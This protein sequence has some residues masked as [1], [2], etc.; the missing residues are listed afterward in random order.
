MNRLAAWLRRVVLRSH[1][2]GSLVWRVADALDP[3][4]PTKPTEPEPRALLDGDAEDA[5]ADAM[6]AEIN[7]MR[8]WPDTGLFSQAPKSAPPN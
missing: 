1:D 7:G 5:A 3:P 4:E 2:V 6:I 8:G